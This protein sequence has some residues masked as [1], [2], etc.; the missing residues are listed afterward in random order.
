MF[1]INDDWLTKFS[2]NGLSSWTRRQM[3][4]IGI[5]WPQRRGWK[6]R[7]IGTTI[8][9]EAKRRFEEIGRNR[10]AKHFSS[11]LF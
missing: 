10:Q 2:A 1:K 3:E 5:E 7:V 6:L 4:L 9:D 11:S 8:D